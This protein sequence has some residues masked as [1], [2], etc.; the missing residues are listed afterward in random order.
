MIKKKAFETDINIISDEYYDTDLE[1]GNCVKECPEGYY[2][3]EDGKSCY[4]VCPEQFYYKASEK[5]K[6]CVSDCKSKSKYF[7]NVVDEKGNIECI[8]KCQETKNGKTTYYYY[9]GTDNQCITSCNIEDNPDKKFSFEA[10]TDHQE[11][12]EEC[13][14]EYKFY[15]ENNKFCLSECTDGYRQNETSDICVSACDKED[16]NFIIE[17]NICSNN[18]T[19][20][21]PFYYPF[22]V[23]GVSMKKCDI[24]C[25]NGG[26]LYKFYIEPEN[27]DTNIDTTS[28]VVSYECVPTCPED[29]LIYGKK[30]VKE[31]PEGMYRENGNCMVKCSADKYYEKNEGKQDYSCKLNCDGDKYISS[32]KEC[33]KFCPLGENF[34]GAGNKCKSSCDS[35]QDG[36]YYYNISVVG[37]IEYNIYQCIKLCDGTDGTDYKHYL[38]GTKEC[39]P[40]CPNDKPY[41]SENENMC[42]SICSKSPS[43]PFSKGDTMVCSTECESDQYYGDD[44]ICVPDCN[45]FKYNK[46]KNNN[47][48]SCVSKCDITS[49]YKY[50]DYQNQACE[51]QCNGYYNLTDFICSTK[52]TE[53]NIYLV[54][55]N[56]CNDKCLE[57]QYANPVTGDNAQ[58]YTYE[59]LSSCR[60]DLFYY[61]QEKI[62]LPSC[63]ENDYVIQGTKK[64]IESCDLIKPEST[65]EPIK[66]Y[67]FYEKWSESST[68]NDNTCVTE[69]PPDK[70]FILHNHCTKECNNEDFKYYTSKDKICLNKCDK[71]WKT[72]GNE[73]VQN[74]PGDKFEDETGDCITSCSSSVAGYYYYYQEKK[75][76][77]KKCNE[78]DYINKVDENDYQCVKSCPKD[79]DTEMYIN[80]K[81]CVDKCPDDKKYFVALFELGEQDINK[82]CLTDCPLDYPYFKVEG[83]LYKCY[84]SC[85]KFFI[86]NKDTNI[87]AK[88]CIPQ[89]T[90]LYP[91]SF[92]H[93]N[94]LKECV[95]QCPDS[96]EFDY[97]NVCYSK[98]PTSAPYHEKNSNS[99]INECPFHTVNYKT[100]ECMTDCEI[101]QYYLMKSTTK[102]CL[103]A[104]NQTNNEIYS[105][106]QKECLSSCDSTKFL[107]ANDKNECVCQG[108][109][110][111][112]SNGDII[113]SDPSQVK[114]CED[115]TGDYQIQLNGTSQCLSNCFGVLSPDETVCYE[116]TTN[117]VNCPPNTIGGLFNGK[118]KC[119]CEFNYYLD[120]NNKKIC[121]GKDETCPDGRYLIPDTK[122]CV[123]KCNDNYQYFFDN[124]CFRNCPSGYD[125]DDS[126]PNNKKCTCNHN[127]YKTLDEK[128]ICLLENEPCVGDFPY[129]VEATKECVKDCGKTGYPILSDNKCFSDCG[130]K[131][132]QSTDTNGNKKCV[133]KYLW[134]YDEKSKTDICEENNYQNCADLN[135]GKSKNFN[136]YIQ[137]I[138]QCVNS[139]PK[140]YNYYFNK[141]CYRTCDEAGLSNQT[142]SFECK[143]K[144]NWKIVDDEKVCFDS[145]NSGNCDDDEYYVQATN[146]CI[147]NTTCPYDSPYLFNSVCYKKCSDADLDLDEDTVNGN[148]C[149]CKHKWYNNNDNKII[150]LAENEECDHEYFPYYIETEKECLRTKE[151]C[152]SKY[153]FNYVCYDQCPL[154]TTENIASETD[155]D[156]L[157]DT[158]K[159]KWYKYTD[160]YGREMLNCSLPECPS[161]KAYYYNETEE[162]VSDCVEI[163]KY[164]YLNIC[165]DECP[166]LTEESEEE[167]ICVLKTEFQKDNLTDLVKDIQTEIVKISES[168]PDGGLVINNDNG[169][170]MQIYKLQKDKKNAH[171]IVRTNLAN[172][173]LSGCIEKIYENNKLRDGEEVVVVQLDIKSKEKKLII[174]PIEYEFRN[175]KTGEILDASVCEKNQLVIS[176]PITY[177]LKN[178][179]KARNLEDDEEIDEQEFIEK[180]SRGKTLNEAD[181]SIDS[182]N[183]NSTIYS[184]IC[185]PIEING[186]DLILEN[187]ISYFYPNYSFC[188]SMCTYDYTDFAGERIYCNCS[189]KN[190]IE[191][192]RPHNAKIVEYNKNETDNNQIGPTNIPVLKCIS[193][194]KIAGNGAFYF[195]I[196]FIIVEFGLVFVY[197]F[198]GISA[199][200]V[201]IRGKAFNEEQGNENIF[202]EDEKINK[203]KINNQV[204]KY[205]STNG[206]LNEKNVKTS[207]RDLEVPPKKNKYDNSSEEEE[208][209][210]KNNNEEINIKTKNKKKSKNIIDEKNNFDIFSDGINNNNE[211][212]D[213]NNYNNTELKKYLQK[214]EVES[215]MGFLFSMKKEEKLLREKYSISLIRDKFDSII[216]VITSIFDKIY[217]IKILLLP[218]KYEI[219]SIMFSLYLLCHLLLLTFSGFF[220][221]IKT[222]KKIWEK[223]NYPDAGYYLL[224]GFISNLI[225]WIIFKIFYCLLDNERMIK[226]NI[227]IRK[228]TFEGKKKERKYN[229]LM[230]VIKR[231]IIIYLC[232]QFALIM[233]CSFYLITFCGIYTGTKNKIFTAYGIAFIEIIIIKIIYGAV[234]GILRK[235]SLYIQNNTMYNVVLILNKYIS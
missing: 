124:K 228:K 52:C 87:K 182:F 90:D 50:L 21:E 11:C 37:N 199:L 66:T 186:K 71:G 221:D 38:E 225:I 153:I 60:S 152:K 75:K 235:V 140:E 1:Y 72:N 166:S 219:V 74:C 101:G 170:T 40:S 169:A 201:K 118:I 99:C 151:E 27:S 78:N 88:E 114:S 214:N 180:F 96:K 139:C 155:K 207:E 69:C 220:F 223:E 53:P 9:N 51:N 33:V 193:K 174:N 133:C 123:I 102:F 61:E 171:P 108:L 173:D 112:E 127:W 100:N 232:I 106:P 122:E 58:K 4:D 26:S 117:T 6:K 142:D 141:N 10:K 135:E 47:D 34:I 222:I 137:S 83:G 14:D 91:Y 183:Y 172:I 147:S 68:Y 54:S 103:D 30:C 45:S 39:V 32:T 154:N 149:K 24:N 218:G 115:I 49:E 16:F 104:C 43:N 44:K 17:G 67:Y 161:S 8:D 132:V 120:A 204:Y 73:C 3:S 2:E 215:Q 76:C 231:N 25:D 79:G 12:H 234:L 138:R 210:E 212:I 56:V 190:G 202:D 41:L 20:D 13:P 63:K 36:E 48:H 28:N 129:L 64:C 176:Y 213:N 7:F 19:K 178:K 80:G 145:G 198:Q 107:R 92:E 224:Y 82:K 144:G 55:D 84:T 119:D 229:K 194:A 156:C 200:T 42:Y 70:P 93:N 131:Y 164:K 185:Y 233:F 209:T 85:D 29:Y 227:L 216:V 125:N 168:L 57:G 77:L 130:E 206:N 126:D 191:I 181:N 208:N 157:C 111:R 31:C 95:S 148:S 162:C 136:Y 167:K 189:I 22:Q 97:E 98:C 217:L 158:S 196:I 5:I 177:M 105:T 146:Q 110:Y 81:E 116:G 23:G 184:N 187:R 121:L 230:K 86:T 188:E 175:S 226:K 134:Y 94:L 46:I 211:N 205:T 143:C 65:D 195:C 18:C 62:C 150:C 165:Y 163:G 179:K 59:C 89:C 109:F 197:I 128:Y 160:E 159:G 203:I 35:S 15:Y 113:C 192:D